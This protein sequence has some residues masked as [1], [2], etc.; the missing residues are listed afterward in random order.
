M[1]FLKRR[2]TSKPDK[3]WASDISKL[4][5]IIW[6]VF[7]FDQVKLSAMQANLSEYQQYLF[8]VFALLL[9]GAMMSSVD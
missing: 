8:V 9:A 7:I 3:P 5:I 4:G 6:T 2:I 1:I